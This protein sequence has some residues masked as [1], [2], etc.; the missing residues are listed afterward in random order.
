M[1]DLENLDDINGYDKK[2][3]E[4]MNRLIEIIDQ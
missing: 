4:K 2:D 3:I 1:S